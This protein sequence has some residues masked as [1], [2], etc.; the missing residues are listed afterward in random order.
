MTLVLLAFSVTCFGCV[1][2]SRSRATRLAL[3]LRLT[4]LIAP[5]AV[6][7]IAASY[8]ATA[9]AVHDA[10][11]GVAM[12]GCAVAAWTD[13]ESGYVF[14][15]VTIPCAFI[16]LCL[17]AFGDAGT[18]IVAA[19]IAAGCLYGLHLATRGRGLGLG[20]VKLAAVFGLAMVPLAT[21]YALALAFVIGAIVCCA[22]LLVRKI[23]RGDAVPFAPFLSSGAALAF[24]IGAHT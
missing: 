3:E 15:V 11:V 2:A 9:D 13:L 7:A 19:S 4:R 22:L 16:V 18:H 8:A 5:V 1:V 10:A 14:D 23:Q 12:G 6:S 20:D 24:V 21:L 17:V